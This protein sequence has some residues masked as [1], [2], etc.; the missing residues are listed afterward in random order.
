MTRP[1]LTHPR[2][3]VRAR[4][5]LRPRLDALEG[6]LLL[7]AGDLDPTFGAGGSVTTSFYT[8]GKKPAQLDAWATAVAMQEIG[9]QEKIV[10]AG[11]ADGSTTGN[12]TGLVGYNLDGSLDTTFG[13]GGKVVSSFSGGALYATNMAVQPDEK[14]VLSGAWTPSGGSAEFAVA[15][16]NA[17]GTP[18]TTF[19]PNHNGLAVTRVNSVFNVGAVLLQPD[20]KIIAAGTSSPSSNQDFTLVRYNADGTIDATFGTGGI[21][22][23]DFQS[24]STDRLVGA[25]LETLVNP[26]GTSSTRIVAVGSSSSTVQLFALARYNLDGS[27]DTTFG[28]GGKVISNFGV[29]GGYGPVVIQPNG[30]IVAGGTITSSQ[31]GQ[32]Y[33]ALARYD[34]AGNPDP[35]FGPNHDGLVILNQ[36]GRTGAHGLALQSDGKIILAGFATNTAGQS[37]GAA[38][39]RFNT[40][41]SLDA[42]FANAG[43]ETVN[44][45]T[46]S[47]AIAVMLQ[48]D[49]KIITAGGV[50]NSPRS[51]VV[52]R[53]QNQAPT[54]TAL[55]SSA[56]PSL[57]GQSVT[58]TATVST[59]GSAAPTGTVSFLDGT[60]LLG[61]GTL[62]TAN[63][64]TTAT[65][66][67]TT[68]AVG[69]HSIT[70]VYGGDS[71]DMGSTSA[72]LSQV[73]N[74]TASTS[75]V[76]GATR[77]AMPA[78]TIASSGPGAFITPLVLDSPDLWDG[79]GLKKRPRSIG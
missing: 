52:A 40:D 56:N 66:T 36:T 33:F 20:G 77:R 32:P 46:Q 38:L 22:T 55:A 9:G 19:G 50:G 4:R 6:R 12:N 11:P 75:L 63:G 49:G 30:M 14:V 26:D 10:A 79:L 5:A 76:I 16:Y 39:A 60:T 78:T 43:F 17:N 18:D 73:V 3:S 31:N 58:F 72:S 70:A 15:R 57:S 59:A 24:G 51:F 44:L 41:G 47:M 42:G 28:T 35:T 23:T 34:T 13:T 53:F 54:T 21:V 61:T 74:A 71:N 1:S 48:P 27:L 25:S 65:F 67:T 45:G 69:T 62:S 64:V 68:L 7:A 37:I 29:S 8:T 2:P